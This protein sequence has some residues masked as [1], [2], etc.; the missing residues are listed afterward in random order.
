MGL[1][2]GRRT[3]WLMV[4]ALLAVV[5]PASSWASQVGGG[6][7]LPA[8]PASAAQIAALAGCADAT[9]HKSANTARWLEACGAVDLTGSP[10]S[11]ARRALAGRAALLGLQADGQDLALLGV[12]QAADQTYVRFRQI[13]RGVP[14]Y[15]GQTLVQYN[16]AGQVVLINNHT[17]P[18]LSLDVTP[19]V[20][21]AAAATVAQAAV[22]GGATLRSP[23][24]RALVVYGGGSKPQLAWHLT[25]Y[26]ARPVAD[27]HV[28]VSATTGKVLGSWD[29][30]FNDSGTG[31]NYDP[32][33]IQQSGTTTLVDG[34]DATT[35]ALDAA[36]VNLTLTNLDSGTFQLKGSAVD[37]TAPGVT[38]C[39]LPYVPGQANEATRAYNYTRDDDRFEEV[40][41]YASV[42]SIQTWFQ[43]LGF[44]NVNNRAIPVNAHCIAA[45]NSFYSSG[46]KA[47]HMGDGGVDDGEDADIV[48]H[49]YGHAV[50]DNQ[51]PGWGPGAVNEQRAMG[52]GFGDFLAG[53]Y[54]INKGD[55]TFMQTYKYCI[56]EW[57]AASYNPIEAGNTGSGCLRW[58]D[59]RNEGNGS[60]IG[61]YSG[62]P[63]SVHNDGRFWSAALTCVYEGMGADAQAR[64]DVMEILIASH[65][66]LTP[67]SSNDGFED[68]VAALVL[69]DQ[70][71]LG[72]AHAQ[73]I[74]TCAL[75]RGL[76]DSVPLPTI[77]APTITA[78]APGATFEAGSVVNITWNTNNA[79]VTATYTLEYSSNCV[80]SNVYLD[81]VENGANG[82][83][84]SHAGG[85]LDWAQVTDAAHSP[86]HSWF[87][88]DDPAVNDQYL[89]SPSIPLTMSAQLS[90]WHQFELEA[91]FDG[92]VV[93]IST[94]DGTSWTDL[95]A[96][97]TENGYNDT[98]STS[99]GSP[100]G[101]RDAF[102]GVS[103]GW[104][105]TQADLNSFNGQTIKL[106][107]R[108]ADDSSEADTGW[109]VDDIAITDKPVWTSIATT[110]PGA[111]SYAW[112]TPNLP[113][114]NYCVRIQAQAAGY[115]PSPL[116][117]GGRFSLTSATAPELNIWLPLL[118]K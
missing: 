18:N 46:D 70:T 80:A 99:W 17:L 57:D 54:Y 87:A 23:L 15:L 7:A 33:A 117:T 88:S 60:D 68:A 10:E 103:G 45:D 100:I 112:T 105:E 50:H 3:R 43:A 74:Q 13:Y 89:V 2:I 90:F 5:V 19:A 96:Q 72:G 27:W 61:V 113:G 55:A 40:T 116:V 16:Q 98:I 118:S 1:A 106:R 66:S 93:E 56:G 29:Q 48:A 73:L 9:L 114:D 110:G 6:A 28:M 24:E 75:E 38:G 78:P 31:L 52:E 30:L 104:V 86:T 49:E 64:D 85:T 67:D 12:Q 11:I 42:T 47:L 69:A 22:E 26:T 65:F 20:S 37:L 94:N 111:S 79:P 58:I 39:D 83:T 34:N 107:F 115:N 4:L 63:T 84:V 36:R 81:N 8:A 102:S 25:L 82:W 77:A 101:G 53:M 76:I 32:N 21:G 44:T 109:W 14:V 59:G 92:G 91:G 71:R 41:A 97:M 95:G 62:T 108:Q 35:P 51:V